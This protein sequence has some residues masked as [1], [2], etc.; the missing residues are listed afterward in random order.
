MNYYTTN[1]CVD[2]VTLGEIIEL[3]YGHISEVVWSMQANGF[4]TLGFRGGEEVVY[5]KG[6]HVKVARVWL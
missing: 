5:T 4:V 1:I 6:E 3:D 2:S